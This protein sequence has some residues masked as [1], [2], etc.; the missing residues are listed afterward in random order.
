MPRR[1]S[2]SSAAVIFSAHDPGMALVVA[3][4]D[5]NGDGVP[6]IVLEGDSG[7]VHGTNTYYAISLGESGRG[8]IRKEYGN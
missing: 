8:L 6:D 7:G 1:Y 4:R 5:V 2:R 3:G